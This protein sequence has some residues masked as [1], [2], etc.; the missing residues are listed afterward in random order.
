MA[1]IYVR[2]LVF[3]NNSV[4]W[5]YRADKGKVLP[6]FQRLMTELKQNTLF[7]PSPLQAKG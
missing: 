4:Q 6:V 3:D 7:W 2:V 1:K 5:G